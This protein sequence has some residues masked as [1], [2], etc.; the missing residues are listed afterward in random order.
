LKDDI[1][2]DVIEEEAARSIE[3]VSYKG[4]FGRAKILFGCF[5]GCLAYFS[6]S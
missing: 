6:Y 3:E 4:L 1:F 5:S 2:D